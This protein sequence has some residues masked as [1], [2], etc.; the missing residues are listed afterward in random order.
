MITPGNG[1]SVEIQESQRPEPLERIIT[2]ID[3]PGRYQNDGDEGKYRED[4]HIDRVEGRLCA[5]ICHS[6]WSI[7]GE[8]VHRGPMVA[9]SR[10]KVFDAGSGEVAWGKTCHDGRIVCIIVLAHQPALMM[11]DQYYPAQFRNTSA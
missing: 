7:L 5:G 2:T 3:S 11:F 1:Q 10:G 8:C 4:D 6:G 9:F